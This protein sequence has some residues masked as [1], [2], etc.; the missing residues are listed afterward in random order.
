M[1]GLLGSNP[2]ADFDPTDVTGADKA[3]QQALQ[4][5]TDCDRQFFGREF[6]KKARATVASKK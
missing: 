1:R 2:R 5:S 6:A 3:L 4:M